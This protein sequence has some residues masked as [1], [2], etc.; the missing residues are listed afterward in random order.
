MTYPGLKVRNVTGGLEPIVNNGNNP[1]R[2]QPGS[3][4]TKVVSRCVFILFSF[5]DKS[6][7]THYRS[8]DITGTNGNSS[9]SVSLIKSSP[10][11]GCFMDSTSSANILVKGLTSGAC[12][13]DAS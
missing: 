9:H 12:I 10:V 4:E 1:T 8:T 7:L 2:C 13:T 6:Q 11:F 3:G 5:F